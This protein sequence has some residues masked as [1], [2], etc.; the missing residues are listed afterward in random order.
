MRSATTVLI[1]ISAHLNKIALWGAVVAVAIMVGA[2]MW[3]VIARYIFSS[4]PIWT[5]ELAR[6]AMV[7]AGMLGASCA[8]HG[9]VNP[10]LFPA[11]LQVKG[12]TGLLYACVRGA[13]A[14]IFVMPVIWYSFIGPNGGFKRGFLSRSMSRT[15]EM[16]DVPMIWFAM[17]IPIAFLLIVIHIL[18]EIAQSIQ[19]ANGS[20]T[21]GQ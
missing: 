20:S 6:Y 5:E 16:L 21:I 11:A 7:W 19:D 4:P 3:Q 1:R 13:G 18:A 17:V 8:F 10:T 12:K 15:A 2:S 9:K 14:M